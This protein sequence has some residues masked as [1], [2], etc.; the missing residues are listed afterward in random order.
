MSNNF[1]AV[2]IRWRLLLFPEQDHAIHSTRDARLVVD[3]F[4]GTIF[5][6]VTQAAVDVGAEQNA[7]SP[8]RENKAG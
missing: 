1:T 4:T 6:Q 8:G 2:S 3:N 5:H 7:E